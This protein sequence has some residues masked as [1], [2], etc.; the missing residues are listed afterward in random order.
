MILS[1]FPSIE[2][3]HLSIDEFHWNLLKIRFD[4]KNNLK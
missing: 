2:G 3:K 1:G 4:F